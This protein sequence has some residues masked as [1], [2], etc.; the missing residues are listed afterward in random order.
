MEIEQEAGSDPEEPLPP[1]ALLYRSSRLHNLPLMA[2]A[3]AHGADVRSASHEEE[4]KTPLIQ[5]VAGVRYTLYNIL[6]TIHTHYTIY[7]T[8]TC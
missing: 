7:Y 6:Y 3:L 8:Y 5:A 1:G 4:G 2:E